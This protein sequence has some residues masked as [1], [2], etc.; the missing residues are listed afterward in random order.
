[1]NKNWSNTALVAYSALPKIA[2]ELDFSL[3]KLVNSSFKSAH[4]KNGVSTLTLIGEIMDVT[5]EKRKIVNLRYIVLSALN[6]MTEEGRRVLVAR[7]IRKR[8]FRELADE[9]GLSIRTVFRRFE[10]AQNEFAHNL[11]IAGY[12]ES[13]LENEY[14]KDPYISRI[15]EQ[16]LADKYVVAKNL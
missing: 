4:L 14:G 8:T 9:L 10:D 1:M 3:A 15:R 11:K 16:F 6:N 2:K 13:W 7:M 5:E 12:G